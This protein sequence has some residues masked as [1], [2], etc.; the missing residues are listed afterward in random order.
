M[1]RTQSW[2]LT[3]IPLPHLPHVRIL[4]WRSRIPVRLVFDITTIKPEDCKTAAYQGAGSE[5]DEEDDQ[6]RGD[7]EA[8]VVSLLDIH[9]GCYVIASAC[10]MSSRNRRERRISCGRSLEIYP[11]LQLIRGFPYGLDGLRG[12]SGSRGLS[13]RIVLG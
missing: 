13:E 12:S 3:P 1:L 2:K 10:G 8:H 6:T 7:L 11:S 9:G 5:Y 4:L